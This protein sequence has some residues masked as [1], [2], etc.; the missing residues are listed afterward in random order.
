MK[1]VITFF[2]KHPTA[3]NLLMIGFIVIGLMTVFNLKKETFPDF[4]S[5]LVQIQ[6]VY[7]GAS[8]EEVEK[9]LCQSVQEALDGI[10]HIQEIRCDAQDGFASTIVEWDEE[11]KFSGLVDDIKTEVEAITSFPDE[12]EDPKIRILERT[13]RV[14]SIAITGPMSNSDLKAYAEQ[15]KLELLAL[16][17]IS[18][19]DVQ[20][21]SDHQVR[22]E[23]P[24]HLL[25]Q[26]GLSLND[27]AQTI[28]KQNTNLPAG[29]ILAHDQDVLVRFSDERQSL[30]AFASL[31]VVSQENGAEIRLGDIAKIQDRF[32]LN[33]VKT[34]FNG[35]RAAI[36]DIN[37]TKAEDSL[38]VGK[39]LRTFV[40][41]KNQSTPPGVNLIITGDTYT[42]VED[43]LTMLVKNGWQGF[44]LVVLT[45]WLFFSLRFAF[46][47]AMG[48]PISFLGTFFVMNWLG[49]SL[50][51]LT[52]VGLLI[53]I[54]LIM[55][56]AIVIAENIYAQMRK[57]KSTVEAAID[58]T[59]GV[60]H[61]VVSSFLTT[62]CVFAPLAFLEGNI[63]KVMRV[64]PVVLIM[65]LS[66][67]LIEAFLILPHHISHALAQKTS[68]HP[69]RRKFE[70]TIEW[71]RDDVFGKLV[72][73]VV[74]W[75]YVFVGGVF[76]TFLIA[77]SLMVNGTVKFKA[78]PEIEGNNIEARVLL[79]QGTPLAFT[80][81]K[82]TTIVD[83]LERVNMRLSPNQP[84]G[85]SLVQNIRIQY[86]QNGDVN[87]AG[88]HVVTVAVDLLGAEIRAGS[89]DTVL[90]QWRDEIGELQD[91]L[92]L[93][94]T[95]PALGP[96]G[97]PIDI[98][99]VGNDLTELKQASLE[100]QAWLK[101]YRGVL[102]VFDDLRPGKKEM[103]LRLKEG[104]LALGLDARA[105]ANQLRS[106]L[107]GVSVGEMY[108][109]A[110]TY[111]ID[112]RLDALDRDSLAD[113]DYFTLT[114]S[115]GLQ[116]PLSSVAYFEPTQ[117]YSRIQRIDGQR[118]VTIQ[119][120]IDPSLINTNE[121]L[122]D[123]KKRFLPQFQKDYSSITIEFAGEAQESAKTLSSLIRAFLIGLLGIFILL[124]FQF[125]T[126]S[127]PLIVMLAIPLS[128]IGVIVGHLV[129]G[130]NLTLPGLIG[131]VSLSGIVVNDSILLITF[132]KRHIVNGI[133]VIKATQQASR[134]RFRAI[135]LTSTTTIVGVA[136]LMLEQ[137]LQAQ[138]LIPLVTSV[139]FGLLASTVIILLMIPAIYSIFHDFGWVQS[140]AES[141]SGHLVP[142]PA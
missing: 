88:P 26:Y 114:T 30:D 35:K 87:E 131:F 76:S 38:K 74:S 108:V 77:L 2:T 111:E 132:I 12:A 117:G 140:S 8:P 133:A 95:E 66:V 94:I 80:E 120:E 31:I 25:R 62:I 9:S 102:S 50:N 20:G 73:V 93:N 123:I 34:L 79:P 136:P 142:V 92:E 126:Y 139:A 84:E 68:Q 48:L 11:G 107:L 10:S 53:A 86:N 27:I 4:S 128:F 122:N 1:A 70:Q 125:R 63:G 82:V 16:P 134:E 69:F 106:S 138:I 100:F 130:L 90:A 105:I 51:M 101:S 47:V 97:R 59:S 57:G 15:I 127:E 43:R 58:G 85:Q 54:G 98:R 71:I 41:L 45:L 110:E 49:Y 109:G 81:S 33:E 42:I 135:F 113:L 67:S 13:D 75:R 64:M 14:A 137:S 91:V 78:F 60:Y 65:T 44:I 21:F 129:M 39:T 19:V 141:T 112:V 37:K 36:L 7:P 89:L 22:I 121:M 29:N 52:M 18:L 61:G 23:I 6:V 99:L 24:S 28:N 5:G 56:D 116:V 17:G 119:G 55:D 72:K 124:S 83:A 32:E 118:T 96:A 115:R 104:A 3:A 46:W 103:S 40:E